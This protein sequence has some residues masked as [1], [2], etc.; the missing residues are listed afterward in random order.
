MNWFLENWMAIVSTISIP[1]AWVFGGKQ[2]KKVEIK[3]SNGDFLTKVQGI[4]DALVEDLKTDRD[5]LKACNIEQSKDISDLR[6]DVR[7]LQK[8]FND[9]YLAYAKEVES[10][11]YWKDKFD[12][13]E[14]KYMQLEK[15]HEALK[16]QFESYKKSNK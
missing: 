2:A 14:G 15:D 8:Q 11:K 7:N 16:K 5:E 12:E 4:Y 6:D 10:S 9:L 13:L 1:V 3:N